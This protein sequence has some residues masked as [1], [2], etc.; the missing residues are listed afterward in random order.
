MSHRGLQNLIGRAI[1][2][3]NFRDRLLDKDREQALADFNLTDDELS[4]VSSIEAQSFEDFA[5]E[6]DEWLEAHD[7]KPRRGRP[8]RLGF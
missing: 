4:V 5:G 7:R 8:S 2:D 6:L 3:R 1:V